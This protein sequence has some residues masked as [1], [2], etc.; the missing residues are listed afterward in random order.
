VTVD[1]AIALTRKLW[2]Q[3]TE[4]AAS[5]VW[6]TEWYADALETA[7]SG[8]FPDTPTRLR[9]VAHLLAHAAYRYDPCGL[10][11][12]GAGGGQPGTVS[13]ITTGRRSV[14]WGGKGPADH[15]ASFGDAEYATTKP[16]QAYIALR[17]RQ[18]AASP[19]MVLPC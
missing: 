4:A 14:T 13:A 2:P 15:A 5:D 1:A 9:A 19:M 16:G 10:L 17:N 3:V 8:W 6:L 18:L 12:G 11:A 7:G